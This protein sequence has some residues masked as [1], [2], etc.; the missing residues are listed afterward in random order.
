[1]HR[2]TGQPLGELPSAGAGAPPVQGAPVTDSGS[3]A[4]SGSEALIASVVARVEGTLNARWDADLESR[5]RR[6]VDE[7]VVAEQE[8]RSWRYEPG[9]F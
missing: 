6:I 8:R 7:R 4:P 9:V 2:S 5:V 1:M 3:A